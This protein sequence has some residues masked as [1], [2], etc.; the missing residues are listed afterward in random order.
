M[1]VENWTLN[2]KLLVWNAW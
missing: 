2:Q 1:T